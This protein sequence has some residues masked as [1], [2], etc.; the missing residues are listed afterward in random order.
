MNLDKK[1]PE[2]RHRIVLLIV[3]IAGVILIICWGLSI[4]TT[5]RISDEERDTALKPFEDLGAH[6]QSGFDTVNGSNTTE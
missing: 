6:V 4:T 5:A 2:V 3:G 1:S